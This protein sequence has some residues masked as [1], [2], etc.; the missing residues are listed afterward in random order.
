MN[1]VTVRTVVCIIH[2]CLAYKHGALRAVKD[3]IKVKKWCACREVIFSLYVRLH[4]VLG[5]HCLNTRGTLYVR[6]CASVE[7]KLSS[8]RSVHAASTVR[9]VSPLQRTLR[10]A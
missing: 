7:T 6:A 9:E 5:L 10:T 8:Q 2:R 1:A 4:Y 3:L